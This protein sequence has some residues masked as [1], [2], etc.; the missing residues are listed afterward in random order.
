MR[1]FGLNITLKRSAPA[2]KPTNPFDDRWYQ[3][4][5][6]FSNNGSPP[7]TPESALTNS[8]VYSCVK[9]ISET[10]AAMPLIL[11]KRTGDRSKERASS[12][13]AF[14]LLK[15]APNPRMTPMEFK[16]T[17]MGHY[18]LRGNAYAQIIY[19]KDGGLHSLYPLHPARMEVMPELDENNEPTGLAAYFYREA[20]G[21]TIF[22]PQREIFH[23]RGPSGDGLTG[24]SP[25]ESIR[26]VVAQ[27]ISMDAYTENFYTNSASPTGI[28]SMPPG[29]QLTPKAKDNLREEWQKRYGGAN[30]AQ[31]IAVLEEGLTWQQI[32]MSSADAQFVDTYKLS[33]LKIAR[34]FRVPPHKIGLMD[35][36]KFSNI[37]QQNIEFHTDTMLPHLTRFEEAAERDFL[38]GEKPDKYFFEFLSDS[39]LRGDT[40]TRYK[41]HSIARQWG[42]KSVND[43][44]AE[45]NM[46][47]IDGGD[48]YLQSLNMIDA[49]EASDYLM[50]EPESP[51]AQP[52]IK[53]DGQDPSDPTLGSPS[54]ASK[55]P[56]ALKRMISDATDRRTA[57]ILSEVQRTREALEHRLNLA[58]ETLKAG[59]K[60]QGFANFERYS[61]Q[62]SKINEENEEKPQKTRT[63]CITASFGAVRSAATDMFADIFARFVRKELAARQTAEKKGKLDTFDEEFYSKQCEQLREALMPSTRFYVEQVRFSARDSDFRQ[64][65]PESDVGIAAASAVEEAL[66]HYLDR[67]KSSNDA[68]GTSRALAV[69]LV[70]RVEKHSAPERIEV[71]PPK[72]KTFTDTPR[73]KVTV[74]RENGSK[75]FY[76]EPIEDEQPAEAA[77]K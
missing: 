42:W 34:C 56:F 6:F 49:T 35:G 48:T 14:K 15:S 31:N 70:L 20:N 55:L 32:G 44:R 5:P 74:G 68:E 51:G 40:I 9:V 65:L 46:N 50:K 24:R 22:F 39:V 71:P 54:E 13:P 11:Y 41:A 61:S 75:V 69:S 72:K 52:G 1:F 21:R 67:H 62:N 16:E 25:L 37:E 18:L 47:E 59:I 63:D 76:L 17:L 28:L 64:V 77:A 38:S 7:V 10:L 3:P 43:I 23:L 4:F 19:A 58:E 2:S 66:A 60:M 30:R 73:K 26:G 29:S 45:E 33:D 36:S 57:D 27:G 53:L 8:A 12:H